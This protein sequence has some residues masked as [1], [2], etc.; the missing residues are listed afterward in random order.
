MVKVFSVQVAFDI[1]VFL[2]VEGSK[3]LLVVEDQELLF[4]LLAKFG[5]IFEQIY[6]VF[7]PNG[8][9]LQVCISSDH[10]S[11]SLFKAHL[12]TSNNCAGSELSSIH[13]GFVHFIPI[14]ILSFLYKYDFQTLVEFMLYDLP[15]FECPQLEAM[16]HMSDEGSVLIIHK[17]VKWILDAFSQLLN[18]SF[19]VK[20]VLFLPFLLDFII[21]CLFCFFNLSSS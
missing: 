2:L 18:L 16:Q 6:P 15:L 8:L 4:N 20:L 21:E 5:V 13:L 11:I 10:E 9:T 19:G 12:K 7:L 17:G 1:F 3:H 14:L